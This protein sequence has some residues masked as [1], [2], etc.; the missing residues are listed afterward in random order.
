MSTPEKDHS[1]RL[2][3]LELVAVML[4]VLVKMRIKKTN[5][6]L[7]PVTGQSE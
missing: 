3:L 2:L 4:L 1:F 7:Q 6:Q 5:L